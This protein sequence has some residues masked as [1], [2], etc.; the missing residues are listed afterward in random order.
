MK[1]STFK[2]TMYGLSL[3]IAG[4]IS[5]DVGLVYKHFN[6]DKSKHAIRTWSQEDV[7]YPQE[8]QRDN[9]NLMLAP[10]REIKLDGDKT[11]EYRT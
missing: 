3:L 11:K 10:Y 4:A 8:S 9:M 5:Y 6:G 7:V 1:R 2:T